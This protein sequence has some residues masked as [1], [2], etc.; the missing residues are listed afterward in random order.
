MDESGR[1]TRSTTSG[2]CPARATG[3]CSP[4]RARRLARTTRARPHS[5]SQRTGLRLWGMAEDALL[6]ALAERLGRL[7]DLGALQVADL[8]GE[9]LD[10]GRRPRR[11]RR[12]TRRGGRGP[13]PGWPAPAGGRAAGRRS[14]PPPGRRWSRCPPRPTACPTLTAWRA[15]TSRVRSRRIWRAHRATLAPMVV[16]SAWMPWVRPTMGTSRELP[17]PVGDGL[18]EGGGGID[19]EVGGPG[20][21]ERQGGVDHVGGREPV[22]DP[23]PGRLADPVGHDVDEGGH[24]VV[25]DP[26]PLLDVGHVGGGERRRPLPDSGHVV[27][28]DRAR[29]ATRPPRPG[30]RPP[31]RWRT[32]LVAPQ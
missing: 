3:R 20:E 23:G 29:A 26:L 18:L 13:A 15:R 12:R 8:E 11:R 30:S 4:G 17:G 21:G 14:A 6:G 7:A 25:G 9:G 24:V 19:Q 5:C 16:G 1:M 28:G 22:V 2:R 10:R 32:G 27:G 31:A